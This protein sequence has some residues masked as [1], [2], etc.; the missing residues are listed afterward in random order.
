ME[1]HQIFVF[2][3]FEYFVVK[4]FFLNEVAPQNR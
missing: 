4:L 3:Y 2:V 1:R